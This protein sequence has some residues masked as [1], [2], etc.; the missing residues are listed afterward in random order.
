MTTANWLLQ[1][2]AQ[3]ANLM[4]AT[5]APILVHGHQPKGLY[6]L[7]SQHLA[8]ELCEAAASTK[9]C[10]QCPGC[11]MRLAGNHPDLRYL[12]PQAKA[13]ELG[14]NV[15][16]KSG[17]KPSQDIRIDD[18]RDL[19]N[20]FNTASSRG[21]SRYVLVYPFDHMNANTA[22]ALLKTLEEPANGLRFV[23]VG[24]RID[25]LLPTIRSRCQELTM[26]MPA[27]A[28][29]LRWLEEQGV[30][31]ADVALGVA[32]N[33]PFEAL[34][35][36]KNSVDQLDLRKKFLD[37][38]A[39]P[40]QHANPPAGLEKVGLPI[41]LELAMRLCSDCVA[42]ALGLKGSN[43]PWLQPK[44]MWVK[45]VGV[46]RLSQLYQN[47]QKEFRLANHP[48]NPRLALEYVGQQWQNLNK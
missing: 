22:N 4:Q 8:E 17:V 36:A 32:M 31:Q 38:L 35:L 37:W 11:H 18:V 23:L 43:F 6:E 42:Q 40:E 5:T 33:D 28:D 15:E 10:L 46:D 39:N 13:L 1:A 45:A 2:Q 7:A 44:L 12:M 19:Q 24:S 29:C 30:A 41:V 14:F 9:P 3:L 47:L 16:V 20:Y 26:P 25:K 21:A 27:I 34:D 48:I